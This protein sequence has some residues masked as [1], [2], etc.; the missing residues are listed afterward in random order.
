M[1]REIVLPPGAV[2][3]QKMI[4]RYDGEHIKLVQGRAR[5]PMICD[6]SGNRIVAGDTVF[7]VSVWKDGQDNMEGWEAEFI[8]VEPS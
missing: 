7:A 2:F 8:E 1:K 5:K 6:A 4:G 3:W